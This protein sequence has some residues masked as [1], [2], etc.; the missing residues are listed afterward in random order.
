MR[1]QVIV[2]AGPSGSGK[3]R[4][5]ERLGLPVLRLDDFYKDGDDPTLPLIATGANAGLVDWD[6][7]DSWLLDDALDALRRLCAEGRA[8]VPV[9][10]IA[11]NGR[12]GTRP[13]DLGGAPLFV[14]EG[15]FAADV[16][17]PAAAEGLLAAA[18]CVRRSVVRTFWFRLTRDLRERRKPP[19]VLVRRGLALARAQRGVVAAAVERGCV[20]RSPD[21][22]RAEVA[23]LLA[24]RVTRA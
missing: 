23:A 1:A 17:G 21:E 5:A 2:L 16:V 19:L 8:D 3:S 20:P 4:L 13:V 12:T 6:R 18:Y 11:A 14:A 7:L 9:Y 24:T 22:V 10:E 15:I